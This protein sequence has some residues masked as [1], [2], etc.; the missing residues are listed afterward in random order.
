MI[1][2]RYENDNPLNLG[3]QRNT[4][5]TDICDYN[6]GGY[7][8]G[9]FSWYCPE[10]YEGQWG[11]YY[12]CLKKKKRLYRKVAIEVLLADFPDL[13][14][15]KS[16]KELQTDEYAIAFRLADDDF[17][18]MKR[19]LNNVWYDKLGA[20]S[21]RRLTTK[22]VFANSWKTPSGMPRYKGKITLFAKKY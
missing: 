3:Y 13:R 12:M 19:G 1:Y 9:T 2:G 15:I 11:R 5:N 18:F 6:C 17:H 21:I 8:L 10:E 20:S 22:E 4:T 14:V 7:A 16:L